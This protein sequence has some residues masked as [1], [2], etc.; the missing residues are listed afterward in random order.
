V[1][2]VLQNLNEF[3][4]ILGKICLHLKIDKK[5]VDIEENLSEVNSKL[6]NMLLLFQLDMFLERD[7]VGMAY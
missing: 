6:Q 2:T 7:R 1:S 5:I 3:N 4:Q